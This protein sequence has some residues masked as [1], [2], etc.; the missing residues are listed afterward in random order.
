VIFRTARLWFYAAAALASACLGRTAQA[1]EAAWLAAL[2]SERAVDREAALFQLGD[3]GLHDGP[4]MTMVTELLAD[5]VAAVRWNAVAALRKA[6]GE[7]TAAL[8]ERI[9]DERPGAPVWMTF[10]GICSAS[11]MFVPSRGEFAAAA[12]ATVQEM[13]R[14][15]LWERYLETSGPPK[16]RLEEVISAARVV[17]PLAVLRLLHRRS[18]KEVNTALQRITVGDAPS[19]RA[20][21][22]VVRA[23]RAEGNASLEL[24]VAKALARLGDLG[25]DAST[26]LLPGSPRPQDWFGP[27]YRYEAKL[28]PYDSF[29]D[30]FSDEALSDRVAQL[31]DLDKLPLQARAFRDAALSGPADAL[32]D[33]ASTLADFRVDDDDSGEKWHRRWVNAVGDHAARAFLAQP[34]PDSTVGRLHLAKA[35]MHFV[36][37]PGVQQQLVDLLLR[38]A[39][40]SYSDRTQV[41]KYVYESLGDSL[42]SLTAAVAAQLSAR[43]QAAFWA[44]LLRLIE[45]KPPLESLVA[46]GRFDKRAPVSLSDVMIQALPLPAQDSQSVVAAQVVALV[47]QRRLSASA[48]Y[49][50]SDYFNRHRT[51]DDILVQ[52]WRAAL[53]AAVP[54]DIKNGQEGPLVELLMTV[55]AD[56]VD[57]ID[58]ARR[59][60]D[61]APSAPLSEV[62]DALT[63]LAMHPS[64]AEW[65][66]ARLVARLHAAKDPTAADLLARALVRGHGYLDE[67]ANTRSDPGNPRIATAWAVVSDPSAKLMTRSLLARTLFESFFSRHPEAAVWVPRAAAALAFTDGSADKAILTYLVYVASNNS[68]QSGQEAS[69]TWLDVRLRERLAQGMRRLLVTSGAHAGLAAQVWRHYGLPADATV[70]RLDQQHEARVQARDRRVRSRTTLADL[71]QLLSLSEGAP[72]RAAGFQRLLS[73]RSGVVVCAAVDVLPEMGSDAVPVASEILRWYLS[74]NRSEVDGLVL[75]SN[76]YCGPKRVKVRDLFVRRLSILPSGL[77]RNIVR[78]AVESNRPQAPDERAFTA[79]KRPEEVITER[80]LDYALEWWDGFDGDGQNE[81]VDTWFVRSNYHP[82]WEPS[83]AQVNDLLME[84]RKGH[85]P[86]WWEEREGKAVREAFIAALPS[87]IGKVLVQQLNSPDAPGPDWVALAETLWLPPNESPKISDAQKL[88]STV[89]PWAR[90]ASAPLAAR[91]PMIVPALRARLLPIVVAS[92]PGDIAIQTVLDV[93]LQSPVAGERAQAL[94]L[95]AS[96]TAND[97]RFRQPF[98][99]ELAARTLERKLSPD[100]NAVFAALRDPNVGCPMSSNSVRSPL[101][102]FP[103]PPP[104]GYRTPEPLELAWF[105]SSGATSGAWFERMKAIFAG[106]STDYQLGLFSGPPGGFALVARIERID[107]NGQ[108]FP[109]RARW[110][111]SGSAKLNLEELLGDLFLERP[112]YFRVVTFVVTDQANFKGDPAKRLPNLDDDMAAPVMPPDLAAMPLKDKHILALVY[113][114]ARPAGQAMHAWLD[115]SPSA[116]RHLQAAG[117]WDQFVIRQ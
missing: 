6:G 94:R 106:L 102:E 57:D 35:A 36:H 99:A 45:A 76:V 107:A 8:I 70:D 63:T 48:L 65:A 61:A 31:R 67:Y 17:P 101:P 52:A 49:Q 41:S 96:M 100:M 60:V 3:A 28:A 38:L 5:P 39:T 69:V 59:A 15:L 110:T 93:S 43:D 97:T 46:G 53:R 24:P 47:L 115:G 25:N 116:R 77:R 14:D 18:A 19:V 95:V 85:L 27:G 87:D 91:W 71:S 109:G 51:N 29:S 66:Q 79:L 30:F 32:R 55:G 83:A 92:E 12:L 33:L 89:D 103:W 78:R 22:E 13:D 42:G 7:A 2:H 21:I 4:A 68:I 64:S 90:L 73:S 10:K 44:S 117:L 98:L 37:Q 1:D 16:L 104:S 111:T 114:F 88:V 50:Q 62:V 113:S 56:D 26:E 86:L 72:G 54:L 84:D 112:G 58:Q 82:G 105:G 40:V 80:T 81:S 34:V 108:P 74:P 75:R 20:L 9:E 23:A 11:R